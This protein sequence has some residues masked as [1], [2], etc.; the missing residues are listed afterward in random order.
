[1]SRLQPVPGDDDPIVF[2]GTGTT[3][4]GM[5]RRPARSVR[6]TCLTCGLRTRPM[7]LRTANFCRSCGRDF[8][9]IR[10][11][12]LDMGGSSWLAGP[13]APGV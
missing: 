8:S 11:L 1:M 4:H 13:R 10:A 2:L 7:N 5:R 9:S 12:V 3:S 6:A